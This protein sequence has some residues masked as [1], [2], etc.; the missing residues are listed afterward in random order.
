MCNADTSNTAVHTVIGPASLEDNEH[1]WMLWSKPNPSDGNVTIQYYLP[2]A[3][4]VTVQIRDILGS[5][6]MNI[7]PGM[8]EAGMHEYPVQMN[9][10]PAGVYYYTLQT[11]D[12][13]I[14]KSMTIIK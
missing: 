6:I 9:T 1:A 5:S 12:M 13:S 8:M 10:M 7:E 3:S 11:S 4:K 2:S 14:T